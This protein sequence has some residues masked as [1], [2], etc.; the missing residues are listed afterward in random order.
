ML[1]VAENRRISPG[2]ERRPAVRP[3]GGLRGASVGVVRVVQVESRCS[4]SRSSE[5]EDEDLNG[6]NDEDGDEG[7]KNVCTRSVAGL[8]TSG[9]EARD[10]LMAVA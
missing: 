4:C 7:W 9:T 8:T 3:E 2:R 5:A 10:V 1:L 6:E